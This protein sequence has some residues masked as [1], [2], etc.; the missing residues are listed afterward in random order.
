[1]TR[2]RDIANLVDANG[3]I[4]AGALDNVPAADLVNDTTPQLGGALDAQ[5]NNVHNVGNLAVGTTSYNSY[6]GYSTLT[7]DHPTNGGLI[8]I[9]RNGTVVGEIWA[10][11]ANTFAMQAVGARS[12]SFRTN[13]SNRMTVNNNGYVLKPAQPAFKANYAGSGFTVSAN[14]KVSH[15]RQIMD[16]GGVYDPANDRFTAPI[17]GKYVMLFNIIFRGNYSNAWIEFMKNGSKLTNEGGRMH[18]STNEG[19]NW[20]TVWMCHVLN[21]SANDYVEVFNGGSQVEYHGNDWHQW[22]GYLLG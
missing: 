9:E 1:M 20:H 11:D 15:N 2:A 4:V 18:F 21:L 14:A 7:L 8:D 5:T 16:I 6:G 17:D 19:S 22:S 3:D 13:A 12:L 10:D